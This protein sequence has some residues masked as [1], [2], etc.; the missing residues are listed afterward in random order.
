LVN[1]KVNGNEKDLFIGRDDE[2]NRLLNEVNNSDRSI[3][4]LTGELGVGKSALLN[5]FERRLAGDEKV[6]VG[7]YSKKE[8]QF[9]QHCWYLCFAVHLKRF[10]WPDE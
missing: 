10:D 3:T 1:S 8:V 5:E 2:V 7:Y 4:L 6:F 9:R